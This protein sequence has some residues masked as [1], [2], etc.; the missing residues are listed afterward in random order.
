MSNG[1]IVQDLGNKKIITQNSAILN[2]RLEIAGANI[3]IENLDIDFHVVLDHSDKPDKSHITIWNLSDT[4]FQKIFEKMSAVDL[5]VWHGNDEPQLLFRGYPANPAKTQSYSG[6]INNAK[7]FL[8]S[9]VKQDRKGQFDNATIIE[10]VDG[11]IG[12]EQTTIN[13]TYRTSVTSTQIINDCI[14]AMGVGVNKISKD[15]P[16]K[17]Y[18][19]FKAKGK[20]NVILNNIIKSLGGNWCVQNGLIQILSGN[21]KSDGTFAVLLNEDNSEKPI[22]HGKEDIILNTR[23]IP[24][25]KP[26]AY[27]KVEKDTLNGIFKVSKAIHEGSNTGT[28]ASTQVVITVPKTNKKKSKKKKESV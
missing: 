22:Q 5:Y 15:L 16:E 12:F 24:F 28:G 7:G 27:V 6:R 17:T 2:A 8:E 1:F 23:F 4:T 10:L 25:L 18:T 11:K 3:A 9:P 26:N 13:K 14:E 19:S 20:P 21:E